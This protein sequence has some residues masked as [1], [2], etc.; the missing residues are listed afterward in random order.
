MNVNLLYPNKE[1][2]NTRRYYDIDGIIKDLGIDVLV[3]QSSRKESFICQT[4]KRVMMVE[5]RLCMPPLLSLL[6]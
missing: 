5:P 6:I 4:M 3:D 2:V 1:W